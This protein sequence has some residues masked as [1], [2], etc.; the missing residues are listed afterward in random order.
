MLWPNCGDCKFGD[1]GGEC[2]YTKEAQFPWRETAAMRAAGVA[3]YGCCGYWHGH[4]DE[5]R[6]ARCKAVNRSLDE[7]RPING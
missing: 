1:S 2:S 6:R 3:R 5:T 7:T 4:G